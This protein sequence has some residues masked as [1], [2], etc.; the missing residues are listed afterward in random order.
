MIK[1]RVFQKRIK[2]KVLAMAMTAVMTS[3]FVPLTADAA[4]DLTKLPWTAATPTITGAYLNTGD[5]VIQENCSGS[6]K[7]CQGHVVALRTGQAKGSK[8]KKKRVYLSDSLQCGSQHRQFIGCRKSPGYP[9]CRN[10]GTH[11]AGL[12]QRQP[13]TLGRTYDRQHLGR[14]KQLLLYLGKIRRKSDPVTYICAHR[15]QTFCFH[16]CPHRSKTYF[17]LETRRR[18][19]H[20]KI[21]LARVLLFSVRY[22]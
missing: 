17:V 15:R 2:G 5:V 13:V 9:Y 4:E 7:T 20:Q 21:S 19:Y 6:G 8:N 22:F 16:G 3:L 12:P 10:H 14:G 18:I 11:I 1:D